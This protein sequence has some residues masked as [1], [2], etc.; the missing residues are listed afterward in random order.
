MLVF[1]SGAAKGIDKTRFVP[2]GK[3]SQLLHLAPIKLNALDQLH[4]VYVRFRQF[5]G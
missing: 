1:R 3:H 2:V 4:E 5:L